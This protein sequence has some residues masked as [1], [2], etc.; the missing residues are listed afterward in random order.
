MVFKEAHWLL[1]IVVGWIAAIGPGTIEGRYLPAAAPMKLIGAK[2]LFDGRHKVEIYGESAR[3]RPSCN[4]E[5]IE[6][7]LGER[8]TRSV[9]TTVDV[10]PP[11]VRSDGVFIFGPWF[12]VL[13]T[14]VDFLEYSYAD[15][16]HQCHYLGVPSLWL[17]RSRFW[18]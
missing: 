5:R 17:T 6:W 10:G 1:F 15:V 4:F 16:L 2:S 11:K 14:I 13:P 8:Q 18:N 9:P 12:V 7:R 3:L